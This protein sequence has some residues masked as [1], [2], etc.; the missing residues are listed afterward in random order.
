MSEHDREKESL[1]GLLHCLDSLVV[2]A[3]G[4]LDEHG[5]RS[6]HIKLALNRIRQ[7]MPFRTTID[8]EPINRQTDSYRKSVNET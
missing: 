1:Y 3:C 7:A 8:V 6:A 4:E 2:A 5:I